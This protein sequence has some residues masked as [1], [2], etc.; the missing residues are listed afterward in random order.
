MMR[1]I[2]ALSVVLILGSCS[3]DPHFITDKQYRRQ[4]KEQFE[5][6]RSQ[7]RAREQQLFSVF[8]NGLSRQETEALEF[9]YA[10]M[11]LSDLADYDG[12][13]FLKNVH[14][15]FIAR[16]SMSWGNRVP[17][18]LFRH[19][20]LPIRVN[21]EN[22]DSSRWVFYEELKSRVRNL[23]MKDAVL[24]VNHWCHEKVTYRGTDGRT[25]SPLATVKTAY[26][27]C[28]EESTFTVAALRSVGIPARQCYTPRWAH[29][30]DNHAWVEAWVD[31][32]WYFIGACEPE[33]DLN[34]A[35]F[36]EPAKRAMLVSTNVFGD[37]RG[38]EDVLVKDEL[39]TRINTLQNY[40]EVK[41]LQAKVTDESGKP[42]DSAV[43][44]FQIYNY[45]EFYP[46]HKTWTDANGNAAFL[47]GFGDL[48]VWAAKDGLF[49]FTKADLRT[50]DTVL[51]VLDKR[52]GFT[53]SAFLDLV[54]PAKQ[55]VT[56]STSDSLKEL[57]AGRLEL[58]DKIRAGYEATFIDSAK[59][60]RLAGTLK[61]NGDSLWD[62]LRMSRGNWM[63][64]V[65]FLREVNDSVKSRVFPLLYS[66][67][68]KDL[69]DIDPSVLIDHINFSAVYPP[70]SGDRD[71]FTGY[72]LCPRFDNEYLKPWKNRFQKEFE[73][74]FVL[75]ARENPQIIV[76]W[77]KEN[78]NVDRTG[79]YGRAP[80][81]PVG[82]FELGVADPQSLNIFFTALCRSFGIPARIDMATRI[83]QYMANGTWNDVLFDPR[84]GEENQRARLTLQ[85][86]PGDADK[87]EYSIHFTVERLKDGFYRTLDYETNPV[88]R[89][90]PAT[91]DVLPGSYLVVTGN[92]NAEGTVLASLNFFPLS[93]KDPANVTLTLRKDFPEPSQAGRIDPAFLENKVRQ[94]IPE[95]SLKKGAILAWVEPDREPTKHFVSDLVN[96][97][98]DF[99]GWNGPVVL[100]FRNDSERADFIKRNRP[101]LPSNAIFITP[102]QGLLG[103]ILGKLNR[104]F[105][106]H[107]PVVV[108]V[109]ENGEVL[110]LSEGYQINLGH[111]LIKLLK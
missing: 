27:R 29:S 102:D 82:V 81:T 69:R 59:S 94:W 1:L 86:L 74:S 63:D 2:L 39:F 87:M 48:L 35:W 21:N 40:T 62:I 31:G 77:I 7:A 11:S 49:G 57:N 93:V 65:S 75:R 106:G 52:E 25:S 12:D 28:G 24:E 103:E 110:H 30:D 85:R 54:P 98:Q 5:K 51:V 13:F 76:E 32:Q 71:V 111:S 3:S 99:A 79:N 56:V 18:E 8:N 34:I 96:G 33:Y 97:K 101:S 10:Y 45:S 14:S 100:V 22:L 66:L 67:S 17:E 107:Y 109:N 68:E 50:L 92:R 80:I 55:P 41:R 47:T 20:V 91:V 105:S 9:L 23:S 58:E 26:G 90:F 53:G 6:R 88:M 4:V 15:S 84:P 43:I 60:Y 46:L 108:F 78:I 19:F 64:M 16:D 104:K 38:P 83:P 37:Y 89:S 73:R 95:F 42:V 61:M 44:E 70:L 72:V 36:T